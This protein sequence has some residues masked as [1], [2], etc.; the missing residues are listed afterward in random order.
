MERIMG[1]SALDHTIYDKLISYEL[2][3]WD[4][5]PN[6]LRS[7]ELQNF[8]QN[9][10]GFLSPGE[11]ILTGHMLQNYLKWGLLPSIEGRRYQREHV[12]RCICFCLLKSVI[13][14]DQICSGIELQ[15]DL[16]G[17]QQ[18][19]ETLRSCL[20]QA[21]Y[22]IFIP[23]KTQGMNEVITYENFTVKPD[24]IAV[25]AV[26]YALGWQI[27][28]RLVLQQKGVA[29]LLSEIKEERSRTVML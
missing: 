5:L 20:R 13:N 4:R 7:R 14:L 12:A 16:M 18:A 10:L 22:E 6:L 24:N 15:K 3:A 25:S 9:E 2:P 21:F 1:M 19:Y 26:C 29:A 8:L 11:R 17:T 23:L 27:F 28:T